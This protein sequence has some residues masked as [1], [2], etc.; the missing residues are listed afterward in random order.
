MVLDDFEHEVNEGLMQSLL[1]IM[2]QYSDERIYDF[3]EKAFKGNDS[4]KVS[5]IDVKNVEDFIMVILGTV[6]GDDERTF[7]A[8]KREE[9]MGRTLKEDKFDMPDFGYVRKE[10]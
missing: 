9:K 7:Y 1:N 5:D 6:K 8:V 10:N 2:D 3:M 4:I